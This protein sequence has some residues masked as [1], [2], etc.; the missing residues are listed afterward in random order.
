MRAQSQDHP[1][2]PRVP[3]LHRAALPAGPEI[4]GFRKK[5][6]TKGNNLTLL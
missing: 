3:W 1:D 6:T 4:K 2:Q 5:I